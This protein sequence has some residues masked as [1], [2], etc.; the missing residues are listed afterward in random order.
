MIDVNQEYS[1][2][3]E[4]EYKGEKYKVRDNG[5]ILRMAREGKPKRPKDETWTFGDKIVHGYAQFCG[6]RVHRIVATAFCGN[7]PTDQHVVDHIDTNRQNNRPENLRWLT[8]LENILLNPFTKSK[9]EFLCG[10]IESFL[11]DPSLLN[12]HE[13][14][15]KSFSWM[16][17]VSKE[18][19]QNT[20]RNWQK[21]L[22]KPRF[23]IKSN[24]NPIEEWIF[25]QNHSYETKLNFF[26]N[27]K[28][29]ELNK[30]PDFTP[31]S[32]Q[33]LPQASTNTNGKKTSPTV[34]K[35]KTKKKTEQLTKVKI[36]A[37]DVLFQQVECYFCHNPHFIPFVRY[38][39]DENGLKHDYAEI[40]SDN[41]PD[42]RFGEEFLEVVKKYILEHPEKGYVMGDVK[43]RHSKTVD[44]DYMSYGC[45]EC[46]GIVGDFY[47]ND[48]EM[49]LIYETNESLM[50][51][52]QLKT[53]FE[54][55]VK[56]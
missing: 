43:T 16:R 42:L 30:T 26:E 53:P 56:E 28:P 4:C 14:E 46:D 41:I 10:S 54:T 6:I 44:E 23:E 8:R 40:D 50:N 7:P 2:E 5:A 21:F 33:T 38:L 11:E 18:E 35:K 19:A 36:V 20:L 37:I 29:I 25:K 52:I 34:V 1:R 48:L 24:T 15:D 17:A 31:T 47:L 27:L 55:L 22:S 12:G 45:P 49:E 32:K 3:V 39:V 51:R 13:N 9:I